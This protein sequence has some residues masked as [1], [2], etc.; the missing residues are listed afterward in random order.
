MVYS[1]SRVDKEAPPK[2]SKTPKEAA[3]K[4]VPPRSIRSFTWKKLLILTG[5]F[6]AVVVL[7][8]A[9]LSNGM[10]EACQKRIDRDPHSPFNQWLQLA[11][12]DAC[13]RTFRPEMAADYYRR[14]WDR[15]PNDERRP[16]A[17]L[18]YARSLEDSA[19]SADAISAYQK[20]LNDY[21]DRE[22]K[23]EAV[24]GIERIHFVRP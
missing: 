15:Y 23:K 13:S 5:L 12:A 2:P 18:R 10:M 16:Y 17:W 19:R 3:S 21:P 6:L 1:D 11:I 20:Y 14:F 4:P 8:V 24:A 9:L 22:D 7:P